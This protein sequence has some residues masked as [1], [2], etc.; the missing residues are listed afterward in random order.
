MNPY[1][2][3]QLETAIDGKG[4]YAVQLLTALLAA[5]AKQSLIHTIQVNTLYVL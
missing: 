4:C 5:K 2:H 1:P 3:S